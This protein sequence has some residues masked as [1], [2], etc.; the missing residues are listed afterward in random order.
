M[1]IAGG[2]DLSACDEYP[3]CDTLYEWGLVEFVP[4]VSQ[5]YDRNLNNDEHMLHHAKPKHIIIVAY[6]ATRK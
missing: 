5:A 4:N 1:W 2:K 6:E 3:R